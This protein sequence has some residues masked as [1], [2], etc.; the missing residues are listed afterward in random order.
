M[1]EITGGELLLRSLHAENVRHVWAIPDGTY[2][3]FLEA[4]ERLGPE[5]GIDL[6]VP[7]H[8]AAAAHAADAMTRVTGEPAVV[9]AC[10]G[11]GAANLIAGVLCAQDEG[12]PV[13]AITTT[14]RSDIAYPQQGGM[15]VLDQMAYFR[16]AVK[17]SAQVRHWKRIPDIVRQA[18][19]A[20]MTGRPGPVH[21]EIP[22]DLLMERREF[23]GV[24]LWH[25]DADS[26]GT[27]PGAEQRLVERAAEALVS[28]SFPMI[29]C[30]GGAHRSGAGDELR[31][32]AE[33]LG[34]PVTTGAGS[35][36]ILPDGHSLVHP[37]VSPAA[38]MVKNMADVVLAVGTRIGELD[39][40]GRQPIWGDPAKQTMIQVDADPRSIGLNRRAD[41][42]LVGDA[43]AI[44]GQ[45]L[46]AVRAKT[47][48]RPHY[49]EIESVHA[50]ESKW[51]AELDARLADMDRRPMV[52]GQIF[53][54][55]NEFFPDDA[56]GAIDGGNTC[57]WAAHHMQVRAQRAM[58]W[59]SNAGHLGTG[60]PFA[61]G[62]KIAAPNRT[63]FCVTGDSAFRFNMQE[64]ATAVAY[65]LPIVV[66]V[67]VDGA[68]GM[69]KS[70]QARVWGR[71]APWFGSIHAPVRYDEVAIA[72]G[73]HGEY[74]DRASDLRAALERA[75]ASGKPA[76]IHA[77]VDPV[78][79]ESPPGAALWAAARS[80]SG[81]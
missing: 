1:A 2:M 12:S 64:L 13:V 18:F 61:I 75:T 37:P 16:P 56:V 4:L 29:H 60:L 78:E 73:C 65:R 21:I 17:W 53:T 48:P 28:A 14:R 20:A 72:M 24:A 62:A 43:R 68:Y 34:C 67:A 38:S 6:L 3:I 26:A 66:V 52:P 22:E 54:V 79:N 44:A 45:L 27:R 40:W 49:S 8:E 55:T 9:M 31:Q 69:E 50:A 36:G 46:A 41:L 57:V 35:R 71:E 47:P 81:G 5:L 23:D 15:Q 39:F 51:R 59:T 32:L 77:A 7:A 80:M 30:G 42:A 33:H 63:V 10:A 19:R 58:L 70:A 76:V 74:V 11:P 25:A